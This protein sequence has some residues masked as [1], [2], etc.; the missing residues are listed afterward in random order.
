MIN[1]CKKLWIS[2]HYQTRSRNLARELDLVIK[3]YFRDDN[4]FLRHFFSSLW[5]LKILLVHKPKVIVI[6]YSFLLLILTAFYKFLR[7][8][9]VKLIVDCHT[10][11]LRRRAEGLSNVLFWQLKSISFKN[12]D[13]TIISNEG[14]VPDIQK[15]H[16]NFVILPD[17]IPAYNYLDIP[18]KNEKYCVYVSSFAVDEPVREIVDVAK[19]LQ[20]VIKIYWTGKYPSYIKDLVSEQGNII[21]T[22]Y[23]TEKEYFRTIKNAEC[24]LALTTE[25]DCLQSA[26]Y[27]A[28]SVEVPFV[29]SKTNALMNF[30]GNAG[31]Y[32]SHTPAQIAESIEYTLKNKNDIIDTVRK[33]KEL[34]KNE[35]QQQI[36]EVKK[37]LD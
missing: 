5:T 17:K 13:L 34:K 10:K 24:I 19:I 27:E 32:T 31:I 16:N 9:R 15:L 18:S 23:L 7:F 33:V 29:V 20:N 3:E 21:L 28:L 30:F 22:G 35:F 37:Y 26:A 11:A 25:E 8:N 6:Q 4:V 2:W 1:R 12:A 36:L 14:L